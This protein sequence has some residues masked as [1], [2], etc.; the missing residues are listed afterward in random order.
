M[1]ASY[2]C[3]APDKHNH[4]LVSDN[5]SFTGVVSSSFSTI[6]F[7]DHIMK[8]CNRMQMCLQGQM[9]EKHWSSVFMIVPLMWKAQVSFPYPVWPSSPPPPSHPVD[10]LRTL[11]MKETRKTLFCVFSHY[12]HFRLNPQQWIWLRHSFQSY[13]KTTLYN[14]VP[15]VS[16]SLTSNNSIYLSR[17]M[18]ISTF[19]N[20]WFKSKVVSVNVI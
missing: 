20:T 7:C 3:L 18:F 14:K 6:N 9:V 1:L 5:G 19:T 2:S 12:S 13:K 10:S 8:T 15:F 11:L 4:S 16:N 17:F